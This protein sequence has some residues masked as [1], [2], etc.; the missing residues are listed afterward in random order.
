MEELHLVASEVA[1]MPEELSNHKGGHFCGC[2]YGPKVF[3]DKIY[4]KYVKNKYK[5]MI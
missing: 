1:K 5:E 3:W 2:N 4:C